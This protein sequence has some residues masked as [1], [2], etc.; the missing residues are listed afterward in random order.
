MWLLCS[1]LLT[2]WLFGVW[3]YYR[4]YY[5]YITQHYINVMFVVHLISKELKFNTGFEFTFI[6]PIKTK[7]ESDSMFG[8]LKQSKTIQATF[9]STCVFMFL[10]Y[11]IMNKYPINS[12]GRSLKKPG[13]L[14]LNL[15]G[16]YTKACLRE[17]RL[18]QRI[19]ALISDTD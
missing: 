18:W 3:C 8:L 1:G 9:S 7:T 6:N 4:Y 10:F 17:F 5:Y 13:E 16:N 2:V 12:F 14:F 19:K 11:L 15:Q